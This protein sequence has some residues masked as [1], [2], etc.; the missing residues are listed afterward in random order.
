M[1]DGVDLGGVT[2]SGDTD[3][4]IN[5]LCI[6]VSACPSFSFQIC[7]P[8]ISFLRT[9]LVETEDKDW[10]VD[11]EAEDLW[12][13]ECKRLS[14]N[15]DQALALLAV[16]DCGGGLLLAEALHALGGRRHV[17]WSTGGRMRWVGVDF[18][19]QMQL[20]FEVRDDGENELL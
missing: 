10:L 20:A 3:S 18:L 6:P 4:D 13:D 8:L 17:G 7:P 11:L 9:E 14:V 15:L 19:S 2:T 5:T 12:L 16:G 1:S